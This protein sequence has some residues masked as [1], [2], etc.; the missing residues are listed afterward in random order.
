MQSVYTLRDCLAEY[1]SAE[2]S[3]KVS[4][5]TK[6][7]R[8]KGLFT[9]GSVPFGYKVVDKK[10]VIKYIEVLGYGKESY[11]ILDAQRKIFISASID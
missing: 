4:H 7:V 5:G 2:L 9:G 1:Y 11:G 3:Q 8:N 6:E 10:V